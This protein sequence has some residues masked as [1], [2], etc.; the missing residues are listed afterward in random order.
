MNY[1]LELALLNKK[2]IE[3]M[4]EINRRDLGYKCSN[5]DICYAMNGSLRPKFDRIRADAEM[6]I[7]EWKAE[8]KT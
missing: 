8:A 1:K 6:I 5:V 2:Q 4:R 7:N 3:V